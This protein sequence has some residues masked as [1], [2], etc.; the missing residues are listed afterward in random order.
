VN[1]AALHRRGFTLIELLV[2][3]AIIALLVSVLLPSLAKAREQ[4]RK[5]VCLSNLHQM[6]NGMS[7]YS[8]DFRQTLPPRG[9]SYAYS[10]REA[11]VRD[12]RDLPATL[13]NY[14]RLWGKYV[15]KDIKLFYC[16]SNMEISYQNRQYGG[17]RFYDLSANPVH[18]GYIYAVPMK[19]A[20]SPR[21]AGR[22]AYKEHVWAGYDSWAQDRIAQGHPDPR[23]RILKALASDNLV[24]RG[25]GLGMGHFIHRTG[26]NVLFTDFHAKWVPDPEGI[27]ARINNGIGPTSGNPANADQ[28]GYRLDPLWTAWDILSSS[29]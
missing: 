19:P 24:S 5:T 25:G 20:K 8:S 1:G 9:V 26:Y 16:P 3:V 23:K 10:I 4:A 14:G 13:T 11:T 17:I 15:G 6:G 29:P 7:A 2:V 22:D 21:D 12:I 27:I 28:P 18:G